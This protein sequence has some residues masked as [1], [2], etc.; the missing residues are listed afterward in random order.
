MTETD[1]WINAD[2]ASPESR[3]SAKKTAA[4]RK[5]TPMGKGKE[6]KGNRDDSTHEH[7]TRSSSK[8]TLRPKSAGGPE[9]KAR[10]P[11]KHRRGVDPPDDSTPSDGEEEA[12]ASTLERQQSSDTTLGAATVAA[13]TQGP[14][15]ASTRGGAS[16]G[17]RKKSAKSR[18]DGPANKKAPYGKEQVDSSASSRRGSS[19]R[20]TKAARSLGD[21]PASKKA[22]P[23]PDEEKGESS[24]SRSSTGV[25]SAR[26]EGKHPS[27]ANRTHL[28]G[29][30]R[31]SFA[32]HGGNL[33][34]DTGDSDP[35]GSDLDATRSDG[36]SSRTS[37]DSEDQSD[38][39][40]GFTSNR[41]TA[42][43]MG[44][45]QHQFPISDR[46]TPAAS[47]QFILKWVQAIAAGP[48]TF[49]RALNRERSR[50]Q[51]PPVTFAMIPGASTRIKVAHGI[52]VIA[53]D[54]EQHHEEGKIG[55]FLGDRISVHVDGNAHQRDP[56]LYVV[57]DFQELLT[58]YRGTVASHAN[59]LKAEHHFLPR[60][61]KGS[62]VFIPQLFPLPRA[63]WPF[64]LSGK[65][66]PGEAYRWIAQATRTWNTADGKTAAQLARQWGQA[67][68]TQTAADNDTSKVAIRIRTPNM[69]EATIPWAVRRLASYLPPAQPNPPQ[70]ARNHTPPPIGTDTTHHD[71][72]HQAV[73]LAH[74]VLQTVTERT[75]RE[76]STGKQ[77]PDTLLC[78][79]LGLSGLSWD[80][81]DMLAPIWQQLYQQPDKA[82]KEVALRTFFQGLGAQCPAFRHFRNSLLFDHILTHKF[83][84]GAAYETCHHGLSLLAVSLRSF[85]DQE[86]ER[87]DDECFEQAT[88][89]TPEAVRK[90]STKTPPPLPTS[91]GELL[92]L[93]DRFIVLTVGLFTIHCSL[94]I[95]LRDL[96]NA[97]QDKEHRLMGTPDVTYDLIPQLVWAV[98]ATARDFYGHISTRPD[99]D[100]ED[101]TPR[102]AIAQLS[103]Y[104]TMLKA[105]LKLDLAGVPEQ[106]KRKAPSNTTSTHATGQADGNNSRKKDKDDTSKRHGSDP[107]NTTGGQKVTKHVN[108]KVPRI[109]EECDALRRLKAAGPFKLND[110]VSEAGIQGGPQRLDVTGLPANVCLNYL[111]F[112]SCAWAKC[113]RNHVHDVDDAAVTALFQQLEPGIVR[114]ADKKKQKTSQ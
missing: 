14:L 58:Q 32:T 106:W 26:R 36:D 16:T 42:H 61:K 104:T 48:T 22:P 105:G 31:V 76:R 29:S 95:Q 111:C 97:L 89:K 43:P 51:R 23:I 52:E 86:R 9:S 41:E 69:D 68:C 74:N 49:E 65:R 7:Y 87:Q 80:E 73:L 12:L 71:I 25:A 40:N 18:G 85:A 82:S 93:L 92:Q 50:G 78:N 101:G 33:L 84:P 63:W 13:S 17:R 88:N 90:H 59:C 108:P 83:E 10:A 20:E 28:S 55:F 67:A 103:I 37:S 2:D 19:G 24:S 56:P 27:E 72:C 8:T 62:P 75:D 57:Q 107:F 38:D 99:V 77:I 45:L 54:D 44:S 21:T 110:M 64:F 11:A 35:P 113:K 94:A 102:L 60:P 114:L 79:L 109:F 91:I 53:L 46:D 81:R 100:P 39:E 6:N 5:T 96:Q 15:S 66:T 3:A 47:A 4:K 34:S 70:E 112:G 98:I 1:D 30:P